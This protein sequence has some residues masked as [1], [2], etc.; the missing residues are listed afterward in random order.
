MGEFFILFTNILTENLGVSE[1][2]SLRQFKCRKY[3]TF[4]FKC[5]NQELEISGGFPNISGNL[6]WIAGLLTPN[7]VGGDRKGGLR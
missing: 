5:G 2:Y 6:A 4:T 7:W 3:H 1:C